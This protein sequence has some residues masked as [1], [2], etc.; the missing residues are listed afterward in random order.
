[1]WEFCEEGRDSLAQMT[2]NQITNEEEEIICILGINADYIAV[3][4]IK[5][6]SGKKWDLIEYFIVPSSRS[7]LEF[8]SR[9]AISPR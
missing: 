1:M 3:E 9:M 6:K 7:Q 2:I 8:S 5:V 4:L